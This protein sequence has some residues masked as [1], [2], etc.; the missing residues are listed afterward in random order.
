MKIN[1]AHIREHSTSGGWINFAV[2]EADS[3]NGT[4]SGRADVLHNLTMRARANRLQID[5]SALVY[6]QNG[7]IMYYGTPDLVDYLSNNGV[8][9]WT[10]SLDL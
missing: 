10:H 3:N 6:T 2:F 7:R 4:D 1:F 5:K 8:P 9:R